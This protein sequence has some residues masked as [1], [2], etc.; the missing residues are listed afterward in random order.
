MHRRS[1][2]LRLINRDESYGLLSLF[3]VNKNL[4]IHYGS[5]KN[6]VYVKDGGFIE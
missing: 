2:T 1:K 5:Y 3:F 4:V 6:N